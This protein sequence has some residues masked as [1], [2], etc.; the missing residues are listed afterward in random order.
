V[1]PHA[2]HRFCV[3]HLHANCKAKGYIG[4]AFKD[5]LWGAAQATNRMYALIFS[6][7]VRGGTTKCTLIDSTPYSMNNTASVHS[8]V[9]NVRYFL[10]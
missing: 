1:L 5:K 4:K 2:E 10:D 6:A 7:D 9:P 3:Q 8:K